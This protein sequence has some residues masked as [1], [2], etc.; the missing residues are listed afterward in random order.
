MGLLG[1][2]SSTKAHLMEQEVG[3][4]GATQ[5]RE[6]GSSCSGLKR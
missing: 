4:K 1:L 6:G 3:D 2:N 5:R